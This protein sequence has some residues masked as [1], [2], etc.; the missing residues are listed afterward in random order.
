MAFGNAFDQGQAQA[1]ASLAFAGTGEPEKWLKNALP[2][3]FGH[4]RASVA[5]GQDNPVALDG[6]TGFDTA[7]GRSEF[8]GVEEQ[9]QEDLFQR[10]LVGTDVAGDLAQIVQ[11]DLETAVQGQ[12]GR[13]SP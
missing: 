3:C 8:Q 4:A 12:G 13:Q 7:T 10:R 2:P 11:D 1:D 9:V 5:D 6:G